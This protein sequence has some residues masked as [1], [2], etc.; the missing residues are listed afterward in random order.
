MGQH[1]GRGRMGSLKTRLKAQSRRIWSFKSV[2]EANETKK[3][4]LLFSKTGSI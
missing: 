4:S 1:R 3:L 2:G